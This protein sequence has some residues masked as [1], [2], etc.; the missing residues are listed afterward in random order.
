MS[1][2]RGCSCGLDKGEYHLCTRTDCLRRPTLASM[3]PYSMDDVIKDGKPDMSDSKSPANSRQV[4]GSHYASSLQHW[5]LIVDHDIGY[6]E[7]CATKYVSRHR[8]KHGVQDLEKAL[9]F[10]DK[11]IE[12]IESDKRYAPTQRARP[13]PEKLL[14][15]AQA[16]ELNATEALVVY[17]LCTYSTKA[18]VEAARQGIQRLIN[19]SPAFKLRSVTTEQESPRGFNA[20]EDGA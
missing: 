9:H 8:K 6:L 20:A 12:A 13:T 17:H 4:G 1:H 3:F 19:E 14:L 5:D 7:G 11:L 16:N 18:H 10:V 2:D 15:F